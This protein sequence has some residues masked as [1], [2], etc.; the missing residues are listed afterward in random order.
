MG[1]KGPRINS[2]TGR[3]TV[4]HRQEYKAR[5]WWK[6][7]TQ[8]D[9]EGRTTT[10]L[11]THYGY[12]DEIAFQL[13]GQAYYH[14]NFEAVDRPIPADFTKPSV[15][16]HIQLGIDSGTWDLKSNERV[17]AIQKILA[18]RPVTVEESN[19]YASVVIKKSE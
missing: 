16:V 14:L 1:V 12:L 18:G 5:G 10:Q 2:V 3:G 8:G 9:C 4:K 19:Y 13:G 11:G 6:V 15:C 7:S 17:D